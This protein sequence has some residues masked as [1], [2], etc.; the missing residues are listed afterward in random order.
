MNSNRKYQ[1]SFSDRFRDEY[2]AW[3]SGRFAVR[4]AL[5]VILPQVPIAEN[6]HVDYEQQHR[7]FAH[8]RSWS[9]WRRWL[10]WNLYFPWRRSW[11]SRYVSPSFGIRTSE[12]E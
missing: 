10:Y 3:R 5:E 12:D 1:L 8:F 2:A 11:D 9:C 4:S 6:L 7:R